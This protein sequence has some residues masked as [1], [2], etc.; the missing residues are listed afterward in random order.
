LSQKRKG[1]RDGN[2]QEESKKIERKK[3]SVGR[4]PTTDSTNGLR[5]FAMHSADEESSSLLRKLR[6]ERPQN[7]AFAAATVETSKVDPETAAI[8]YLHQALDSK[9]VP[10]FTAPTVGDAKSEFKSL[11]TETI[12]LIASNRTHQAAIYR[13]TSSKFRVKKV[14]LAIRGRTSRVLTRLDSASLRIGL[15]FSSNSYVPLCESNHQL[16]PRLP[17]VPQ[18]CCL[19]NAALFMMQS[20]PID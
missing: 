4:V 20:E 11:G 18:F 16:R 14:A 6:E 2:S 13:R 1:E 17:K 9:S 8:R 7:L 19:T 12:P 3:A 10:S 15:D 5:T